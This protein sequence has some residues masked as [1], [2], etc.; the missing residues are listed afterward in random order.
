MSNKYSQKYKIKKYL[1]I[2]DTVTRDELNTLV[3]VCRLLDITIVSEEEYIHE[4]DLDLLKHVSYVL[5][6]DKVFKE[7]NKIYTLSNVQS[8]RLEDKIKDKKFHI[9]ILIYKLD[10]FIFKAIVSELSNYFDDITIEVIVSKKKDAEK[11]IE[12]NI[13]NDFN[14]DFVISIF[15]N[16]KILF[17]SHIREIA[18]ILNNNE[19][20]KNE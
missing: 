19:E 16:K 9:S 20:E 14:F 4:E 6:V 18:N 17:H 8:F 3:K 11:I 2:D 15:V 10:T 12:M 5:S 7:K 13:F 1:S